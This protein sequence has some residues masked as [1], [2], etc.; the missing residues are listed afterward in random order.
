MKMNACKRR[1]RPRR[2]RLVEEHSPQISP[3]AREIK[4]RI[5]RLNPS[6]YSGP[7]VHIR[8]EETG[9]SS[10][11]EDQEQDQPSLSLSTP[12]ATPHETTVYGNGRTIRLRGTTT[13]H[14]DGG[15]S[16]ILNRR[17][18]PASGC[19]NCERG[20]TRIRG[21]LVIRYRVTTTVTLPSVNDYPGLTPCQRRRVQDAIDNVLAPHEQKHVRAFETYNGTTRHP[22][23]LKVCNAEEASQRL[24]EIHDSEET[25]RQAS[26]Q[27]ASDALDPFH[28]DVDL[29]C[30]DDS[31]EG[32]DEP[33][34]GATPTAATA[35]SSTLRGAE[36]EAEAKPQPEVEPESGEESE[37]EA[38]EEQTP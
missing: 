32:G 17:D 25:T 21:T 38:I 4:Q 2:K 7:A 12:E 11:K 22:F 20:C 6:Y 33:G 18:T 35:S 26:A 8:P 28:F 15:T 14:F 34:S 27:A 1:L 19:Q 36:T 10:R 16:Q 30:E 3:S 23:D 24:Q 31:S 29:D 5:D 37:S 13:P 9:T